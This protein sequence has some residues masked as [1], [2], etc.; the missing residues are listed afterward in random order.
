MGL[1]RDAVCTGVSESVRAG[2]RRPAGGHS[3]GRR[4]LDAEGG[5]GEGGWGEGGS[6]PQAAAA[7]DGGALVSG[8]VSLLS[9][10]AQQG[11]GGECGSFE[12]QVTARARALRG[13]GCRRGGSGSSGAGIPGEPVTAA[14]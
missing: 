7:N 5:A 14:A 3:A 10:A 13:W 11:W 8:G 12:A 9:G 2:G 4:D 6:R 1:H